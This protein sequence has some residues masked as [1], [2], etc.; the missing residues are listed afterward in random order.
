MLREAL[1]G[2]ARRIDDP[3]FLALLG[4]DGIAIE[5]LDYPKAAEMDTELVCVE[6]ASLLRAL[7][8]SH[9]EFED[10]SG[11]A[12]LSVSLGKVRVELSRFEEDV[13]LLAVSSAENH[14][15]RLR[16]EVRR[17][18]LQLSQIFD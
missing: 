15:S 17:A 8:Q 3:W 12:G 14:P 5:S 1:E 9:E 16:Y 4:P 10:G 6:A 2:V 7:A 18:S 11:V 13:Y